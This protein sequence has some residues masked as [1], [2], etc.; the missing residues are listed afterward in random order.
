MKRAPNRSTIH[1]CFIRTKF[2]VLLLICEHEMLMMIAVLVNTV[3]MIM[4]TMMM[5][6]MGWERIQTPPAGGSYI[7]PLSVQ[8]LHSLFVQYSFHIKSCIFICTVQFL[9]QIMYIYMYSTVFISNHVYL[10]V[11]YS[12]YIKS[13]IAVITFTA[14]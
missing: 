8:F 13:C 11:Q 3:M 12:F 7:S 1:R 9:Y 4:R 2:T 5:D 14:F 10:Y 6:W